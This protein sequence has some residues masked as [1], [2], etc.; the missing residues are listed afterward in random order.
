[1]AN[2]RRSWNLCRIGIV[3]S[4][5]IILVLA[6]GHIQ[7]ARRITFRNGTGVGLTQEDVVTKVG[8][9]NAVVTSALDFSR[10]PLAAYEHSQRP[11]SAEAMV[12]LRFGRMIVVYL[13]DDDEVVATYWG[14]RRGN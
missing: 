3:L 9:P 2:S 1:M 6:V 12:Y 13:D 8:R 10:P 5:L 7:N 14:Q 4:W 11:M